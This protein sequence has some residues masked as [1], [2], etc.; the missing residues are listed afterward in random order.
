MKL[1]L[2]DILLSDAAARAICW[3][4][5]HSLWQGIL[6]AA[7]A[8]III[9]CTR[10]L[11]AVL[12]YNLLAAD[13]LF[14]LL[15]AA[16]TFYYE[17][18]QAAGPAE[19]TP[20]RP[21]SGTTTGPTAF[22]QQ[23]MLAGPA[24][25]A[26]MMQQTGDYLNAHAGMITLIWLACLSIQLMRLTGGL[27]RLS[28]IRR[29]SGPLPGEYWNERLS[30]LTQ[31]LGIGRTVT[32][33]QSQWVKVPSAFGF[34]KP[35]ILVPLGML[36][37]LPPDQVEAVLL[38]ELAHIRRG[39]YAVNLLLLLTEAIFF[40][41]PGMRWIA[42]LIRRE[43]EACCDDIV[44]A[45]TPDKDCYF[46][47]L[48]AFTQWAVNGQAIAGLSYAPQLSG[49]KTDLLWRIKRMLNQ[50]NKKLQVMEKAILSVGLMALV[51]VSLISMTKVT[52]P[53]ATITPAAAVSTATPRITAT[54][55]KTDT[56]PQDKQDNSNG[57]KISFRSFSSHTDSDDGRVKS[58]VIAIDQ[59]GNRYE[60][61]RKN[62]EVIEFTLNDQQIPRE[63]YSR[64]SGVLT[65]IETERKKIP[66]A[67]AAP[68][69]PVPAAPIT[70]VT[71]AAPVGP[72]TP[73][74]SA[75]PATLPAPKAL[76]TPVTPITSVTPVTSTTRTTSTTPVTPV[77][78]VAPVNPGWSN[79]FGINERTEHAPTLAS[80][81]V[82]T[83]NP[84]PY[85]VNI[86]ADL[87]ENGLIA[88]VNRFSFTLNA[89]ELIVNGTIEPDNIFST[90][91]AK[92]MIHPKAYYIYS[93]YYTPKGSGSHSQVNT[94]PDSTTI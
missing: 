9:G 59:E 20:L 68:V 53:A 64:Y 71:P 37:Q 93:Q 90:F 49:G 51:S 14:F 26:N 22:F 84:D 17:M 83:K 7:L 38:H 35:S 43:R 34:L 57:K 91:R 44:L 88:D 11:P 41:N 72:A 94:D 13:G 52:A 24:T 27:Y 10:R 50:E 25:P 16:A 62:N 15:V 46:E 61:I 55:A 81:L 79:G 40:F 54:V 89:E 21:A 87:V 33:L 92:Y 19:A 12:R 67:P 8:G 31:R 58:R 63:E 80:P 29:R 23:E 65:S 56:V 32:L 5:V 77:T 66:K 28:R 6:A 47:A 39:D 70:A 45:G 86:V 69:P 85:I 18:G 2:I 78:P 76:A 1:P 75:V 82:Y 73:R 4:L 42:S 36:S 60:V 3:T 30:V 48:V 74:V